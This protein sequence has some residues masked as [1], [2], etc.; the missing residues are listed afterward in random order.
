MPSWTSSVAASRSLEEFSL[1]SL[2]ADRLAAFFLKLFHRTK[3]MSL[4]NRAT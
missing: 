4:R 2:Q 3:G 1:K